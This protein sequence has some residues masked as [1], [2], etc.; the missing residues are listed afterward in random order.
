M[1]TAGIPPGLLLA[2][3]FML[4]IILWCSLDHSIAGERGASRPGWRG[5][6]G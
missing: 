1:F 5:A 6:R 4:T 2:A 3:L